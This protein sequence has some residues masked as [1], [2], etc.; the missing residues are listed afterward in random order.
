MTAR[1]TEIDKYL[2]RIRKLHT[3]GLTLA[4]IGEELGVGCWVIFS[5][6]KEM[7]LEPNKKADAANRMREIPRKCLSTSVV[8]LEPLCIP[9]ALQV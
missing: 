6:I 7:G 4:E 2:G 8:L 9:S 1:N 5:R 3:I